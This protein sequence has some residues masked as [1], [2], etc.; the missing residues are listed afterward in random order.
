MRFRFKAPHGVDR[1]R[2][3]EASTLEEALREIAELRR[4]LA[5]LTEQL[6]FTVGK[7][8]SSQSDSEK[9]KGRY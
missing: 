1:G 3:S 7:E 2:A 6:E 5:A 9:E 4:W 8:N